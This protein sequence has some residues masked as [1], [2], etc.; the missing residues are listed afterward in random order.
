MNKFV[1]LTVGDTKINRRN[2]VE[3]L[4]IIKECNPSSTSRHLLIHVY[5]LIFSKPEFNRTFALSVSDHGCLLTF[6][7]VDVSMM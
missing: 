4:G 5:F 6:A 7:A 2:E 1:S 3:T